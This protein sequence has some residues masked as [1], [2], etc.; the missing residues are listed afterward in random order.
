MCRCIIGRPNFDDEQAVRGDGDGVSFFITQFAHLSIECVVFNTVGEVG[1][2]RAI[3]LRSQQGTTGP[4]KDGPSGMWSVV[5]V[6]K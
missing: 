1:R 3:V 2:G 5:N 4:A 6:W